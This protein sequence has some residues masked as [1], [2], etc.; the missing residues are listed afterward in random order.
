MLLLFHVMPQ[1][2]MTERN[3]SLLLLLVLSTLQ[4]LKYYSPLLRTT[5]IYEVRSTS[6]YYF[7]GFFQT[8]LGICSLIVLKSSGSFKLVDR[9]HWML[10]SA[11]K[12]W[13]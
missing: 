9:V 2:K 4:V 5:I 11:A 3:H 1:M 8:E 7:L 12:R 13:P 6:V 10:I